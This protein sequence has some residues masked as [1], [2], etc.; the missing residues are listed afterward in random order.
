MRKTQL[1][2][3]HAGV[4]RGDLRVDPVAHEVTLRGKPVALSAKE[5]ALLYF[6][7]TALTAVTDNAALT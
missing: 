5:F 6:L 1:R 3:H 4:E 7:A 2:P